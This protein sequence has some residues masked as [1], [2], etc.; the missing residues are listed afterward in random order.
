[1]ARHSLG[2][3]KRRREEREGESGHDLSNRFLLPRKKKGGG[4]GKGRKENDSGEWSPLV[5]EKKG[6]KLTP[7]SMSPLFIIKKKGKKRRKRG[8]NIGGIP[9]ELI[10]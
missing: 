2:K 8:T 9:I 1:V 3:K 4:E 10:F 6:E 5:R 7:T